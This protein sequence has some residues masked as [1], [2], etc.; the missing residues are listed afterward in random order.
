MHLSLH[1]DAVSLKLIDNLWF[2]GTSVLEAITSSV[3]TS[4]QVVY[5]QSPDSSFAKDGGFSYAVVVVGEEPYAEFLGD[6]AS[7]TIP[8]E[9][10]QT[11]QNV[12]TNVKCVVVLISGRPLVVEPH[13]PLM[14]SFVAAWL[15][16]TEG[17][18]ITDV[19]FGDYPFQGKLS[20]TWFRRVNQLPMNMNDEQY[21]PLFPYGFGMTTTAVVGK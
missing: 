19:L 8:S 2:A 11:I 1:C 14:D 13:L 4:T 16:G 5:E 3:S 12:C 18:G 21:D 7:L 20:R 6:S 15:P 17:K 10:I 9:G